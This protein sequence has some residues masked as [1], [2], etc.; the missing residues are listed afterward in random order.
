MYPANCSRHI[1]KSGQIWFPKS[2]VAAHSIGGFKV[3][4]G[5]ALRKCRNCMATAETM[6]KMYYNIG[7]C[8]EMTWFQLLTVIITELFVSCSWSLNVV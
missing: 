1:S 7:L 2:A 6:T 3:G 8:N 4:V 5:F